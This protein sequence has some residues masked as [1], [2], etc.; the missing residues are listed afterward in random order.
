V[1][2]DFVQDVYGPL[3]DGFLLVEQA[4]AELGKASTLWR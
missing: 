1:K 2:S 4:E 3:A